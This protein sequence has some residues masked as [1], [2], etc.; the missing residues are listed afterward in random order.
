MRKILT[1]APM[2]GSYN[3]P[4]DNK[5]RIT[6]PKSIAQILFGE[7]GTGWVYVSNIALLV[8]AS[9]IY[10]YQTFT[11][12]LSENNPLIGEFKDYYVCSPDTQG[13]IILPNEEFKNKKLN[14]YGN[15]DTAI[16]SI[17]PIIS[18]KEY[19]SGKHH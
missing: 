13:R 18:I 5:R 12:N 19:L 14:I 6:I 10:P 1:G 8:D 2:T 17:N 7:Q 4:C 16:I 11:D 9:I 3:V 15:G